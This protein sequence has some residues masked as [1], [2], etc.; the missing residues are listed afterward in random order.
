MREHPMLALTDTLDVLERTPAV[1]HA[2]LAG[3]ADTWTAHGY[4]PGTWSAREVVGHLVAAERADWVPRLHRILEH[5]EAVPFDPFPHDATAAAEPGAG[6]ASLLDEFAA[7]RAGNVR[8]VRALRLAPADLERTGT[9]PALGRVT[10]G[11]LLATWAV[12][13][14]HHTRQI[15]LAMAWQARD[16]VG[17]WRA[18]LNTLDR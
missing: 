15:C 1:L 13:D 17:P 6:L 11:Q 12:H 4:G 16:A 3:V 7:L 9:H 8:A 18:Y 14:L 5:G 10:A 2:L